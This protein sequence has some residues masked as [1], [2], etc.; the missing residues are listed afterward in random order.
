MMPKKHANNNPKIMKQR[1]S[2]KNQ[3]DG[4]DAAE[5]NKKGTLDRPKTL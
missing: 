1:T 4:K 3:N 2:K 5:K